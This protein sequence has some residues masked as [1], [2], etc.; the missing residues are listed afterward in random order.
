MDPAWQPVAAV[1]NPWYNSIMPTLVILQGPDPGRQFFLGSGTSMIGRTPDAAVYLESLAVSRQHAQITDQNKE[2]FVEDLGSSNGTFIN[3]QQVVGRIA[4]TDRDTLQIGPYLMVLRADPPSLRQSDPAIRMQVSA[5]PSSHTLY[6]QNPAHKLQVVMEIAQHLAHTLEVKPL[7]A[8]LLGQLLQLFPQAERGMVLLGTADQF[9][10]HMQQRGKERDL[11]GTPPFSRTLVQ[12]ALTEGIGVLSEDV[13]GDE[14]ISKTATLVAL[15]LRSLLCV[16]LICQ[17]GRRLGVIQL[18]CMRQRMAFT[19]DDLELATAIALQVAVVLDN[20]ALHAEKLREER[21]RQ[22]LK[23]AREIQ[24]G[25]LPTNF[26]PPGIDRYELF[27]RVY[28]AREVSGDL[29]DFFPLEDGRLVFFLG[30][31]SGKGMPAALFMIAV[32]TLGRHLA[33]DA[34]SPAETLRRLNDALAKDNPSAMFVT[35]VHG[36]YD[37]T[38]GEV[39]LAS[40]GHPPPLLRDPDGT[41]EEMTLA[42]GRLLGYPGGK[43]GLADTRLTLTPG[44]TLILYTDGFTEARAPDGQTPFGAARLR[45]EFGGTR[46]QLPLEICA[47]HVRAAVQAFTGSAELQDD[48]TLLLLR[49]K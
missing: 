40:G 41:V 14:K 48:L 28:A 10:V 5:L 35:L 39:V 13:A 47:E 4:L 8:K 46:T 17:D 26:A 49:R 37:P 11:G 30:D 21:F 18:D 20:A 7:L 24:Q 27:A 9:E 3:G 42:T 36:I 32:R 6:A 43:L 31:V 44:S 22:E 1:G 19:E 45:Q 29:Y 25:F 15:N 2:Y 16:P 34:T 12:R 23:L 33:S 38:R